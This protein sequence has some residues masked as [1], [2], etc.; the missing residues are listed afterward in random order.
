MGWTKRVARCNDTERLLQSG[1]E[2]APVVPAP[3]P[4][5]GERRAAAAL[6]SAHTRVDDARRLLAPFRDRSVAA[7]RLVA[8]YASVDAAS[9]DLAAARH[10]QA[11][12]AMDRRRTAPRA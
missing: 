1:R 5:L 2:A 12:A 11:L 8:A 7:P 10:W 3:W 6:A 4:S 9:A